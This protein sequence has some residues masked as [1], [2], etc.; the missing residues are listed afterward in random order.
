M[1]CVTSGFWWLGGRG[2]IVSIS[3]PELVRGMLIC[4]NGGLSLFFS[5]ISWGVF[6][7]R[8]EYL[9]LRLDP[10]SVFRTEQL[11]KLGKN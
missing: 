3:E 8:P 6:R 11:R 2:A 5:L 1:G 7:L 9:S 4:S 10:V